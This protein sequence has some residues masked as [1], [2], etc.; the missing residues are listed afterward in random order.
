MII[1]LNYHISCVGT[2]LPNMNFCA[3]IDIHCST[4]SNQR[5]RLE[6]PIACYLYSQAGC[7]FLEYCNIA[8]NLAMS[9]ADCS[10]EVA[11]S[12]CKFLFFKFL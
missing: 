2:I 7:S 12:T 3:V 11:T 1:F 8:I 10:Y 9:L 4:L 6:I 5:N